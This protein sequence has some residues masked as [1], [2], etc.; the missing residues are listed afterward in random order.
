MQYKKVKAVKI[1][2][3][4]KEKHVVLKLDSIFLEDPTRHL[5]ICISMYIYECVLISVYV[6]SFT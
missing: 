6:N 4:L 3:P 5:Y 1:V 2:P